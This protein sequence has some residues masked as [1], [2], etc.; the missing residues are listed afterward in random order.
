MAGHVPIEPEAQISHIDPT[1]Q[2]RNH[3][4]RTLVLMSVLLV[5]AGKSG[6][7]EPAMH[8]AERRE[9]SPTTLF[10]R[11]LVSVDGRLRV[12]LGAVDRLDQR[13]A[14]AA[15]VKRAAKQLGARRDGNGAPLSRQA[16]QQELDRRGSL[17]MWM[18]HELFGQ[19]LEFLG[20]AHRA[21]LTLGFVAS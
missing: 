20:I 14:T 7:H 3:Q 9:Q 17:W 6:W 15:R 8:A 21:Q 18:R 13:R 16:S 1:L 10:H 19:R 5:R 2:R 11:A 12:A 4:N